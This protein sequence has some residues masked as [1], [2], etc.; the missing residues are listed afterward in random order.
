MAN[1]AEKNRKAKT[2]FE[3]EVLEV[4]HIVQE[5]RLDAECNIVAIVY[6]NPEELFNINLK[7]EDF[8]NNE[9]RVFFEIAY[10]IICVEKKATLDDMTVG[11]YLEKHPRLKDKYLEYGGYEEITKIKE[12]VKVENLNSYIA[13]LRKW[14]AVIELCKKGFP[15][16][17]NL[18]RYADISAEEIYNEFE[19]NLNHVFANIDFDVKSYDICNNIHELID[20]LDQGSAIGLPYYNMPIL[21]KETGGQY[22]GSITL[23]GGLSNAGKSTVA[24]SITI[25]S[26]LNSD[27]RIVIMV[28]ED[29]VSKW[30][31]EMLVWVCNNIL[32]FDIQKH[33]VRDGHYS[34]IVKQTLHEAADWL[35]EKTQNHT[36]IIIPV[37]HRICQVFFA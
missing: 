15:V 1:L 8:S 7:T 32:H 3:Q 31:R 22:L 14:K 12:Y 23:L 20:V 27:E 35:Q 36:I 9:W 16:K 33:V 17:D 4:A 10:Q 29:S 11:F 6:K 2:P 19:A 30:Q 25:P 26:I 13:D 21:T 34:E 28:N 24:R 37:K 5:Y 18:S